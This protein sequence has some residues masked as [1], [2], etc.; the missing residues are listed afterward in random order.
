MCHIGLFLRYQSNFH[1]YQ[2]NFELQESR[3]HALMLMKKKILS[4]H[5]LEMSSSALNQGTAHVG[6][7]MRTH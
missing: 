6:M 3:Q 5:E 7:L 4:Y 1:I 2:S